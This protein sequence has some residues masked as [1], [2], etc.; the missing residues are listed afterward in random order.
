MTSTGPTWTLT[1]RLIDAAG[2][3]V[4]YG[5]VTITP[6]SLPVASGTDTVVE[7]IQLRTDG[8]GDVPNTPLES[9][10]GAVWSL[11]T[12]ANGNANLD[13]PG[14]GAVVQL[15][16]LIPWGAPP[17]SA[18]EAQ[19][20][21]ATLTQEQ[22]L[23]ASAD[24]VLSNRLDTIQG[25]TVPGTGPGGIPLPTFT[26]E[27]AA[28]DS[29][30]AP[31]VT[32]TGDYP[33]F[34]L[35]F[36][37]P[38]GL[39]GPA[40]HD[41]QDGHSPAVSFIG[42]QIVVDGVLGPDLRGE[43][44]YQGLTGPTGP[45]GEVGV[46]GVQGPIGA[47]GATGPK[48]LQG[49]VGPQGPTGPTGA[50]GPVGERGPQGDQG[51]QGVQGPVGPTGLTGATGNTGPAPTVSWDGDALVVE[52]A[53]GPHLTGP[54]GPQGIQ[55]PI[56]LTGADSTVP[57]PQGTAGTPGHSPVIT[58]SGD[59]IAVDSVITG[60]HLTG[61]QGLQ[62]AASTV[63]GPQGTAGHSPVITMTGDQVTVDGTVTGPHLTGAT[64]IQGA[65]GLQGIGWL[66][67]GGAP[68]GTYP[69]GTMYLDTT[70]GDVYAYEA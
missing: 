66:Y 36:D 7:P 64:G 20:L 67:G 11:Q 34:H 29:S 32:A 69:V 51:I 1:G 65:Q 2:N 43:P 40:G 19:S 3:P 38:A 49:D 48:G 12:L 56:G 31:L 18:T 33:D 21:R 10:T 28:V 30:V 47:T 35:A 60:P 59:Q 46:Q 25:I 61:P 16:S 52:G 68:T 42:S 45:R 50:V 5:V 22:V 62:G 39:P 55:G 24:Q 6:A 8:N 13:D 54:Q 37:I 15:N 17:V 41:G 26:T 23:R 57:G 63:P 53:P 58:M 27:A 9:I 44:G 4:K 70:T 14:D